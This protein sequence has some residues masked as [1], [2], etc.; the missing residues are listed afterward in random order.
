MST[1]VRPEG[2]FFIFPL[3]QHLP[4]HAATVGPDSGDVV[5]VEHIYG[6][7]EPL[8]HRQGMAGLREVTVIHHDG[9]LL[10]TSD[11]ADD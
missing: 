6:P 2:F 4:H 1:L 5:A 11:A 8:P 9:C 3:L 7:L 10:Y